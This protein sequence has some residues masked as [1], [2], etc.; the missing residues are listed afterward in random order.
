VILGALLGTGAIQAANLATA[1]IAARALLPEGRG[2]LA[3]VVLWPMLSAQIASL[4]LNEALLVLTASRSGDP[5]RL[6]ATGLWFTLALAAVG[7]A[8]AGL[9]LAPAALALRPDEVQAAGRLCLLLVPASMVSTF[10]LDTVRG[11]LDHRGWIVLR[12][13]QAVTYLLGAALA[14]W[15]GAGLPGFAL[16]F[17][18]SHAFAL[19]VSGARLATT[20]G[21]PLSG[22]GREAARPLVALGLRLHAGFVVQVLGGRID[23][24]AI[25]VLLDSAALGLYAA[26]MTIVLGVLQ[27]AQSVSQAAFPRVLATADL[28]ARAAALR[29]VLVQVLAGVTL[30]AATFALLADLVVRLLFGEAFAPAAE[31]VRLLLL[32]MVPHASREVFMAALKSGDR[33]LAIGRAELLSL[34]F[35]AS[36]LALAVPRLGAAGAAA[37]YAATQWF[38]AAVMAWQS[39]D[40]LR[41]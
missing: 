41:A 15:S 24:I 28:A 18:L 33:P 3:L 22:A 32:G 35:F 2:D 40:L 29:R 25:A 34:A 9:W 12:G 14:W 31:I 23:Q 5:K 1:M 20:G 16:A 7:A 27:L 37:A 30:A 19:A 36:A 38:V 10:F 26:A 6:F 17:V 21:L 13:V 39:R 11:R 8:V 4:S